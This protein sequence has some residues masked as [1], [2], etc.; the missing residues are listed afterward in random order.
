MEKWL[1]AAL[2]YVPQWLG[3]QIRIAQHPGAVLAIAHKG[4]PVFEQAFGLADL[5]AGTK[6]TPRHRFRVASHSKSFTAAGILKLREQGRLSLDDPAG[7]HVKGLHP[8]VAAATLAQLLSHSAGIVR[9]GTDSDQW[10]DRRP[11]LDEEELRAA[12]ALP[13]VID[14]NTRFKYSNHGFGLAGLVIE[15]VTGEPYGRWIEREIVAAAGLAETE[16]DIG[17]VDPAPV[18]TPMA[19]GHSGRLPLG[20]R[21]VIPGRNPTGA[22][23]AATGFVATARDLT[24]FFSGLDPA[25][26]NSVLDVSSRRE[27]VRPQWRSPH[28]SID[29]RYGLGLM[30]GRSAGWDWFG[31]G[32]AFQGFISRTAMLP[33]AGLTI[34]LLTNAID[35]PAAIWVGGVTEILRRF[36]REGP[37]ARRLADWAGRWWSIWRA[38]DL[39]PMGDKVLVAHPELANP[40][41]DAA[42]I[43]VEGRDRGRIALAN[44]FDSHG[45][46]VHRRRN[47][48]GKVVTIRLAGSEG[49]P[50]ARL[51]A[52]MKKRYGGARRRER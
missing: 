44:G 49:W 19:S 16:P 52:E 38:V 6:L 46:E 21:V 43:T 20:R 32:G 37:P 42:E 35:G 13:P 15:A 27:M 2:G 1:Q 36:A 10:V 31:H 26:R 33:E 41:E 17:A 5:A 30:I 9:D 48:R 7:R 34:S 40:F 8:T 29:L 14:A 51:A 47:A 25:A 4:K 28:S 11:F 39:V 22:L 3:H 50:E 18:G 23:A 24:R 12:L 45:E